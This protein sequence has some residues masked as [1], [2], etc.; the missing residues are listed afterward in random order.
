MQVEGQKDTAGFAILHTLGGG[1]RRNHKQVGRV[2]PHPLWRRVEGPPVA[3]GLHVSQ[4]LS[5]LPL[6]ATAVPSTSHWREG[7]RGQDSG[8]GLPGFDSC[9]LHLLPVLETLAKLFFPLCLRF[10]IC[11]MGMTPTGVVGLNKYFDVG[12]VHGR[13]AGI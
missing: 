8:S 11:K 10:L 12:N 13:V 7:L 3:S 1:A 4:P 9:L 2:C 6:G 5:P